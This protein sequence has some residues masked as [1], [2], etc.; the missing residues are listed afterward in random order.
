MT[1][2][3]LVVGLELVEPPAG[4]GHRKQTS[5]PQ[6]LCVEGFAGGLWCGTCTLVI[7]LSPLSNFDQLRYPLFTL[8]GGQ[9]S[10]VCGD[11]VLN[12]HLQA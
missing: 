4:N 12:M 11:P 2:R 10:H 8:D 7:Q 5:R 3:D 1:I 9:S 6:G